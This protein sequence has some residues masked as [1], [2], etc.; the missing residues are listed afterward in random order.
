M[1]PRYD[2]KV[3]I[4]LNPRSRPVYGQDFMARQSLEQFKIGLYDADQGSF[5]SPLARPSLIVSQNPDSEAESIFLAE[6]EADR[7]VIHCHLQWPYL[8]P[9]QKYWLTQ[10]AHVA[11][12]RITPAEFLA[13][14]L[15]EET[16][17]DWVT[18]QNVVDG[19]R[20]YPSKRAE[21]L[22]FR[23]K[24][25]ISESEF[26]VIVVGRIES[27]KGLQVIR[28]LAKKLITG[29]RLLVQYPHERFDK[30]AESIKAQNPNQ[31]T[32]LRDGDG[33]LDRPI[34]HADLLLSPSLMEVAPLVALESLASG[35]RVVATDSTPFYSDEASF[36]VASDDLALVPFVEPVRSLLKRCSRCE[37]ALPEVEV[38]RLAQTILGEIVIRAGS[39]DDLDRQGLA[40]RASR[41]ADLDGHRQSLS[42]L[43]GM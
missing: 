28:S 9:F 10:S 8:D 1:V 43:Y 19:S 14:R 38:E 22:A 13:K 30:L 34:R 17:V 18:V 5:P 3:R 4:L 27:A 29:L 35:V 15:R 37:L 31:V 24:H 33:D 21:R 42:N 26:V 39:W 23:S 41:Y 36:A 32:L 12:V 11:D 7:R 6:V 20:F 25:G 40:A 16:G 2:K